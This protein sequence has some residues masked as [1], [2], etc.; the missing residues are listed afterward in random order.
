[1]QL[2]ELLTK[3]SGHSAAEQVEHIRQAFDAQAAQLDL[4]QRATGRFDGAG[5]SGEAKNYQ[6][7]AHAWMRIAASWP[8]SSRKPSASLATRDFR[9]A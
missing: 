9:T 7:A 6:T 4:R 5:G 8:P 1:M 2:E 3:H